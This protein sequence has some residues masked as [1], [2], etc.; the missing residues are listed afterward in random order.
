MKE[1]RKIIDRRHEEPHEGYPYY[2]RRYTHDRRRINTSAKWRNVEY[3]SDDNTAH[4][5]SG[6][7]TH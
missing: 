3:I 4:M 5:S 7:S 2:Y 1:R 6:K